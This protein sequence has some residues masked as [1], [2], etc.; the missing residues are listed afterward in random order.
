[1][2][3]SISEDRM[4]SNLG[5]INLPFQWAVIKID[6]HNIFNEPAAYQCDIQIDA[7]EMTNQTVGIMYG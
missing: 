1:M 7:S 6:N 4:T 3:Q 2:R 5:C